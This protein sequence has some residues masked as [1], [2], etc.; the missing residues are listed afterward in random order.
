MRGFAARG[1]D[2]YLNLTNNSWSQT[3]SAQI[4]HYVAARFN[5][6]ATRTPLVRSTNSG[7]TG[8]VDAYGRLRSSLPMF[9]QGYLVVDVPIYERA[10]LTFYTRY[11]DY[12][13]QLFI[14]V[15][16]LLLAF[17]RLRELRSPRS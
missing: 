10:R 17:W 3:E 12:L 4:Q 5:A 6:I 13:P 9:E 1:A 11:G 8:L 16:V 7:V 2:M 15:I 14:V